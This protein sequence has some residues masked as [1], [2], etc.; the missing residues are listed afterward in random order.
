MLPAGS[1][2]GP[3]A[4]ESLL[5]AGGMG[6]VYR[7]RDTRLD[8]VVAVKVLPPHASHDP[9]FRERFEREARAISALEH[10]TIC[11]LYDV[12]ENDGTPYLVMQYLEGQTLAQR[13]ESGPVPLDEAV[14]IAAQIAEALAAAHR[15]GIVHRDLKPAN[16]MLLRN[17]GALPAAKLLDFGLAKLAGAGDPA[18]ALATRT[19]AP[20]TAQGTIL[21]TFQYMAPEQIEGDEADARADIFAFGVVV[22]EMLTGCRAFEGKTQASLFG[23]ILKE[24]PPPIGSVRPMTPP[25]L[26]HLVRAC[27]AKHPDE[28]IQTAHDVLLQLRWVAAGGSQVGVPAAIAMKRRRRERVFAAAAGILLMTTAALAAWIVT[29][30]DPAAGV[31]ARFSIALG[32]KDSFSRTGRH[33]VAVSPDGRRI[34]YV[35]NQQLYSRR[36]DEQHAAPIRGSAV[37]PIEPVFSPDGEWIAFYLPTGELR[38]IPAE[39][40]SPVRLAPI[41]NVVGM[42][43]GADGL[44]FGQSEG[45]MRVD[46]DGGAPELL[47]RAPD[48]GAVGHPQWLPD[49]RI[50]FT[51]ARGAIGQWDSN[52]AVVVNRDGSNPQVLMQGGLDFRVLATGH[53]LFGRDE[54]VYVARLDLAAGR[55]TDAIPI[56]ERVARGTGT[57]SVQFAAASS[58]VVAYVASSNI[59]TVPLMWLDRTGQATPASTLTRP[60]EDFAL[61]PDGTR[62]VVTMNTNPLSLWMV[63]LIRETVTRLTFEGDRRDP[64]WSPDGKHVVYTSASG[65]VFLKP[66][67]GSSAERRLDAANA[68]TAPVAFTPDGRWLL[69]RTRSSDLQAIALAPDAG[70]LK[71]A[72]QD[73]SDATVSPDGKWLAYLAF[74]ASGNELY[75]TG[76]PGGGARWQVSQGGA[77]DPKW[78]PNGRELFYR[79][80]N[81]VLSVLV[82]TQQTFKPGL[83]RILFSRPGYAARGPDFSYD[84]RHDR[85]MLLPQAPEGGQ[86]QV[87][88]NWPDELKQRLGIR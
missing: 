15:A 29:R 20:L 3:Y 32:D 51:R 45:I 69:Y 55:A 87:I 46:A 13:L 57:G 34:V 10:P 37:D 24:Q 59:A 63:D 39:G 28:R 31:V 1:R 54:D 62:V 68:R 43:W 47:I 14:A 53:L 12:G 42:S 71:G 6:E 44:L 64:M 38:K 49:G 26:D 8:R 66:A 18:G 88:V 82:D 27:L 35:A 78:H 25:A 76:F 67:D 40:G 75:V 36:L 86:I 84:A 70:T 83:P 11:T 81:D 79:N 74:D 23:A 33:L 9:Q 72:W 7:A 5:G 19:G 60:F 56:V 4:I 21:G 30:P 48:G 16:V 85:F 65:G 80:G 22:Y 61:S 50:L 2:L 58:G 52:E 17:S 73:T 41:A 77:S